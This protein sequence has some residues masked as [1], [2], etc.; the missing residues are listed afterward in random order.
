MLH[1]PTDG[2]RTAIT[3]IC[4]VRPEWSQRTA[5]G[6][7][8]GNF[9]P[10]VTNAL[11]TVQLDRRGHSVN[12]T[13]RPKVSVFLCSVLQ[14]STSKRGAVR[15]RAP[16]RSGQE[17]PPHNEAV[18]RRAPQRRGQETRPTTKE[19]RLTTNE[20]RI[21]GSQFKQK[22]N[23]I[24]AESVGSHAGPRFVAFSKWTRCPSTRT[25]RRHGTVAWA[26]PW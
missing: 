22:R 4:L 12:A 21:M 20:D 23:V 8:L 14:V 1:R 10:L 6:R 3:G 24:G 18:R 26:F 9:Q 11:K 17:T 5:P 25:A 15:R 7:A 2:Q 13:G 16:Q 19:A